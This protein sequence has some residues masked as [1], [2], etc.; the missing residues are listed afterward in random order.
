MQD[1]NW[2]AFGAMKSLQ[3]AQAAEEV[4]EQVKHLNDKIDAERRE[5]KQEQHR[6]NS[7]PQC[8]YCGSR[9]EGQ[10]EL[11]NACTNPI[12]WV[13]GKVGKPGTEAT[14]EVEWQ[15]EQERKRITAE[16]QRVK[17]I[18]QQKVSKQQR[19]TVDL[20]NLRTKA[21]KAQTDTAICVVGMLF[22]M[23]VLAGIGGTEYHSFIAFAL[24]GTAGFLLCL[25]I[26]VWQVRCSQNASK[27]LREAV[28]KRR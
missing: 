1:P 17:N 5:R 18:A 11:C 3:N 22:L 24:G 10:F 19:A 4:K 28:A 26:V 9:L 20:N 6:L 12:I 16:R 8:P 23:F 2:E 27:K 13:H 21:S 7:R 14:L 25:P 15:K